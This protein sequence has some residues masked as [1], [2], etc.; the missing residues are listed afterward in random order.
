MT[1]LTSKPCSGRHCW[2]AISATQMTKFAEQPCLD[3]RA[4]ELNSTLS[5]EELCRSKQGLKCRE[6]LRVTPGCPK[7][8]AHLCVGCHYHGHTYSEILDRYWNCR[9]I[10]KLWRNSETM[11]RFWNVSSILKQW[12]NSETWH[13]FWKLDRFWNCGTILKLD[14]DS[15]N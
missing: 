1:Q 14:A 3:F 9:A 4:K 5:R 2:L 12:N 6:W 15:E 10:L 7:I 11:E 13:R 8:T